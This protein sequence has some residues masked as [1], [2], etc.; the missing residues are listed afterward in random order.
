MNSTSLDEVRSWIDVAQRVVVLTGAGI[1]TD[2]GIPDFRGPQGVWTRNPAAEKASNLRNYVGDPELRAA[3]WS[4]RL[5]SPLFSS[6]PNRGHHA[7]TALEHAARLHA[8]I[9]QNVDE[10]HQKAGVPATKVIEVH[11]TAHRFNCLGCGDEGPI[12][13]MLNRVRAGERDPSCDRCGGIVKTATISF[14]QALVPEVI[15]RAFQVAGEADVFV[16]VGSTLQVYPVANTLPLAHRTGARTVIVNAQETQFDDVAGAVLR[17]SISEIL[18][19]IFSVE[20]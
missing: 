11:G 4:N 3:A 19:V 20:V 16:A 13:V 17:G 6:Q 2:S 15:D 18:P 7:I 12:E 10:L 1:S 5:T 14:G 9:T 8:V